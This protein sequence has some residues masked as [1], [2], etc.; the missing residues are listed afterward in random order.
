VPR[1]SIR[2]GYCLS[3]SGPLSGN[4][5]SAQLAHRIWQE[6]INARGGLLGRS[7]ELVCHDDRG[8]A[9]LVPGLYERLIDE[10]GVDLVMGG[11]GTNS[12]LAAM[13]L[14]IE[15][16][17][18]SK[19]Y[20]ATGGCGFGDI[21]DGKPGDEALHRTCFPCHQPAEDHDFVF[22]HFAPAP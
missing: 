21:K 14:I 12:L 13:P 6:S 19:K 8:D 16:I 7:V 1:R 17:K 3:L 18:D 5:K 10:E 22:A 15:L 4:S 2:I 11:Y 9:S 20:A